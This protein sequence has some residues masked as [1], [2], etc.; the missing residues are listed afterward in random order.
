MMKWI[1]GG[2]VILSIIYAFATGNTTEVSNAALTESQNAIQFI[3]ILLGSMCLWGGFLKIAERSGL[4]VIIAKFLSPFTSLLFPSLK[5]DSKALTAISMN[6]TANLLGLGNAATPFGITAMKALKNE[7][8]SPK[9]DTASH[10][11]ILFILLNTA[12]IQLLPT[13]VATLRL[14]TGS[15]VP[16][17]ILPSVLLTSILSL[18]VGLCSAFCCRK[19]LYTKQRL[20]LR[21]V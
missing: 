20:T 3:L 12:S 13:A 15:Y 5:K 19:V 18:L 21:E 1:F 16:M 11:M 2:M 17:D 7:V 10:S 6:I 8:P 4:T 9:N 14:Q